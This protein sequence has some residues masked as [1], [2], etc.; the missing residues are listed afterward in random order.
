MKIGFVGLQRTAPRQKVMLG[1][2]GPETVVRPAQ[3]LAAA[4]AKSV[5][6]ARPLGIERGSTRACAEGTLEVW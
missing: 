3:P 2:L 1:D 6:E 4:D 5:A